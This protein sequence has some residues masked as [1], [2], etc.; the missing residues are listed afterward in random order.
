MRLALLLVLF[1]VAPASALTIQI[2][3]VSLGASN[4]AD[5]T[6][7]VS[8]AEILT[9]NDSVPDVAGGPF[10]DVDAR[11]AGSV[12]ADDTSAS[13]TANWQITFTVIANPGVVYNLVI[14]QELTGAFSF[15]D[16]SLGGATGSIGELT[17]TLGGLPN[18]L[19]TMPV[20]LDGTAT[21]STTASLPFQRS[22]I[23]EID[24]LVGTQTFT[25]AFDF[26]IDAQSVSDQIAVQLGLPG[27][28]A[29]AA[30]PGVGDRDASADGHHL[31]LS[32]R[33]LSAPP[34]PEPGTFALVS[35][36]LVGLAVR[37]RTRCR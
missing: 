33:V 22:R 24:S 4:T 32:T 16:D 7:N 15:V 36:G 6:N 3:S 27:G 8:A 2:D 5:S 1:L 12:S 19:L 9:A 28:I 14:L 37:G 29:A 21:S 11:W 34:V 31:L 30:Y 13:A 26:A 18:P 25:L 20:G 35:L 17:G 10:A 23:L